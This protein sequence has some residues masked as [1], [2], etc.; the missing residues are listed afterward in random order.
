MNVV[1]SYTPGTWIAK[2]FKRLR[3]AVQIYF[4][5]ACQNPMVIGSNAAFALLVILVLSAPHPVIWT[6][7]T[8]KA[9]KP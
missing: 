2:S 6:F 3:L 5:K 8:Y 4:P 1:K 7:P 9:N